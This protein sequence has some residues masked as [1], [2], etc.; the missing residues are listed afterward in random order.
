MVSFGVV[1]ACVIALLVVAVITSIRK[2][3]TPAPPPTTPIP[4]LPGGDIPPL[5]YATWC[6]GPDKVFSYRGGIF[7][8]PGHFE[9]AR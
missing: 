2:H 7:V 9:C 5:A 6:D 8:V 1:M 4:T 3:D